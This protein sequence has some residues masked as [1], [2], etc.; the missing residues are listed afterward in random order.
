LW[1]GTDNNGL[2]KS[3]CQF[4]KPLIE[5][6]NDGLPSMNI[7]SIKADKQ[8]NLWLLTSAG[9]VEFNI[10]GKK[11]TVFDKKDGI[12]DLDELNSIIVD[13]DGA[14]SI[15]GRGCIYDF[16]PASIVKNNQP[17]EVSITDL[18]VFD[19]DYT[20]H[21]GE[22]I[23]LNYNQNYFSF[24]YVALNY[25]QPRF[26]KYAY[27]MDGLDKK[28]NYAGGR[29]YVSY[30]NLEEGTYV[31]N[32]K[33]CNNEGVWNNV[34]S[35]LILIIIPPVWHRWW[36]YTLFVVVV[37]VVIYIVYRYNMNQFKMRLE[38]RDKIARDLHDDIGS[39][40]SGIN[41]FSKIALQKISY[42]QKSSRDLLEKIS[43][44]SEKTLDAL[45]DIV[46]SI[47][48]RN[49]GLD[50]FLTKAREYLSEVLEPQGI[51]YDFKVD[52]E[53]E[54]LKIGMA[55]RKELYLIFKEAV[56]NASKYS[57]CSFIQICLTKHK[58]ICK[59]TI[60]DN[61][62]GF[63]ID[64][65]SSGNGIYNMKH[66]AKKINALLHIESEENEGT[67]VSLSFNIPRFR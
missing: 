2:L 17:P 27:K 50:N 26:N 43:D 41:I 32:V 22:T 19:K 58:D 62:N 67:L 13:S 10:P 31:F 47:N 44:R 64:A 40:L 21:K 33:A 6:I 24:E 14:I 36:F 51:L 66:R 39:T 4:K 1:I 38:L 55:S 59:L 7:S 60:Q 25:T 18:R 49:D 29:R 61:G 3:N 46:W 11:I 15:A 12:Q 54:H 8:N 28:W 65:V 52:K 63:N 34:P 57:N 45:S 30:A 37:L 53:L 42:D 48:T 20:I 16:N 5:T 23:E 56:C 35:K 9:A